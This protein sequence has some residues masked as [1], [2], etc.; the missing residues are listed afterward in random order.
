ALDVQPLYGLRREDLIVE[1]DREIVDADRM[2]YD[3]WLAARGAAQE[4]GARPSVRVRVVSEW[5]RA[6]ETSS[7]AA[8]GDGVRDVARLEV[9]AV[10]GP[11]PSGPRFGTLVHAALAT[12]ALDATAAHVAE[13]VSL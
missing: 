8:R 1:P 7:D 10:L 13:A 9:A 3:D 2:R 12:V 5:A 4:A 6:A 11:R